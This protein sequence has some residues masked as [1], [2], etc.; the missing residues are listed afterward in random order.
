LHFS[1]AYKITESTWLIY[2]VDSIGNLVN[3]KFYYDSFIEINT[4]NFLDFSSSYSRFYYP[5]DMARSFS[6]N[7]KF[8]LIQFSHYQMNNYLLTFGEQK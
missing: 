7:N 5:I 8:Q 1:N 6:F 2:G 3:F 4:I